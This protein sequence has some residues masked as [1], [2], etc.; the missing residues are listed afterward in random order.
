MR[1]PPAVGVPDRVD[2]FVAVHPAG[3]AVSVAEGNLGAVGHGQRLTS[4]DGTKAAL[5]TRLKVETK[6]VTKKV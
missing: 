3:S 2:V 4:H 6:N 5:Q 1:R